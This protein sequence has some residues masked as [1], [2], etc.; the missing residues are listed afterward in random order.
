MRPEHKGSCRDNALKVEH[1]EGRKTPPRC[2]ICHRNHWRFEKCALRGAEE[3]EH[4][5]AMQRG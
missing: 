4:F 1:G 3:D 2:S 5:L